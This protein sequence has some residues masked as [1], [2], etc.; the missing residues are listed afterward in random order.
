AGPAVSWS[1][2][3]AEVDRASRLRLRGRVESTA[4]HAETVRLWSETF[5]L[6]GRDA[7]AL[8]FDAVYRRMWAFHLAA[9]EAGLRRGWVESVQVLVTA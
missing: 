2:L 7:A 3:V 6:R 5:A 4:H 1:D 9:V 8:G